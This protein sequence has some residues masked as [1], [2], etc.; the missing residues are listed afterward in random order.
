MRGAD[1]QVEEWLY[2][3]AQLCPLA[4]YKEC[5]V[6]YF[7]L[8]DIRQE[9]VRDSLEI[10][11]VVLNLPTTSQNYVGTMQCC[12]ATVSLEGQCESCPDQIVGMLP[13]IFGKEP[14]QVLNRI[15]NYCV[16]IS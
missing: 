3:T 1:S 7:W 15:G 10:V 4:V 9:V 13:W 2:L 14:Q 11:W 6:P 8:C 16:L 12:A 5:P